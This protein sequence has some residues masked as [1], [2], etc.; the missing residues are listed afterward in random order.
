MSDRAAPG[1]SASEHRQQAVEARERRLI[2]LAVD[3]LGPEMPLQGGDHAARGGIEPAVARH[4]VAEAGELFLEL[5]DAALPPRAR[6]RPQP[7]SGGREA[8][9]VEQLARILLALRRDVAVPEYP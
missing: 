4:G 7:D 6:L 3:P 8:R 2:G 9:P 5:R 1:S